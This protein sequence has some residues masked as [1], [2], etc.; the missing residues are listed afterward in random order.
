VLDRERYIPGVVIAEL[1]AMTPEQRASVI[2]ILGGAQDMTIAT[3]RDD[4][5]PQATTVS[6]VHDGITLYFGCDRGSQKA[7]NIDQ[8]DKISLTVNLPYREWRNIRGLSL[9]GRA[10]VVADR[11]EIA[12]VVELMQTRFPQLHDYLAA[13][14]SADVAVV[15]IQPEVISLLDYRQGFGH[16]EEV[17]V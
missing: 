15:R 13:P 1:K 4:G 10:R 3:V 9:G 2:G 14:E 5:Y 8:C 16:T 11:E 17:R 6:F 12:R 7:R